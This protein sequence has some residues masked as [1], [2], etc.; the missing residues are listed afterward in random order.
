M[1]A[2]EKDLFIKQ[3]AAEH[4]PAV[5]D[6][7]LWSLHAVK[8]LRIEG[9]RKAEVESSLKGCIIIEDYPVEGRPLPDCL[10]LGFLG[11]DPVHS[12]IAIDREFDRI[13]MITVYRPSAGRWESDWKKRKKQS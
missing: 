8:K 6:K 5:N 7:I 10:V 2:E 12:V 9:L 13:L 1:T 4:I 3:K 11:Y